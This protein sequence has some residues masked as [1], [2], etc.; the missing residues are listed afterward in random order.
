MAECVRDLKES[1]RK[2]ESNLVVRAG[3]GGVVAG[4]LEQIG[5]GGEGGAGGWECG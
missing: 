5:A 3:P 2:M 4:M 1:L